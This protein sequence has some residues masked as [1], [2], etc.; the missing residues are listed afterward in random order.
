MA[1]TRLSSKG[2]LIIPKPVRDRHG[3]GVGTELEVEDCGDVV[4]LRRAEPT[5][6]RTTIEQVRGSA[7]YDGPPVS[8]EDFD[9]GIAE[10][11]REMWEDFER[12]SR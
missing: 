2:Q 10:H 5:F 9:K 3:W 6:P 12:Q 4:V 8:L 11:I 7:K 1:R